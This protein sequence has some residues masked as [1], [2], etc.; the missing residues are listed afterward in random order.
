MLQAGGREMKSAVN[1]NYIVVMA[2]LVACVFGAYASAATT[3]GESDENLVFVT[4]IPKNATW[5]YSDNNAWPGNMWTDLS[6]DDSSW[7]SGMAYLATANETS[8]EG[9]TTVLAGGNP[10]YMTYYFRHVFYVEDASKVASM[11]FNIDY[12]DAYAIYLNGRMVA[13]SNFYCKWIS[14]PAICVPYHNSMIE[15]GDSGPNDPKFPRFDFNLDQLKY[16]AD[17]RNVLA[18]AIKQAANSSTDAAFMMTLYGWEPKT[19]VDADLLSRLSSY[20]WVVP[21]LAASAV[22][23]SAVAAYVR[24]RRAP[25]AGDYK[26]ERGHSYLLLEDEGS[27]STALFSREMSRGEYSGGLYI[28]RD[29][30]DEMRR[31]LNDGR[32]KVIWLTSMEAGKRVEGSI[33]PSLLDISVVI[34][35]FTSEHNNAIILFDGLQ[36]LINKIGLETI[37]EFL[38][39]LK[40]RVSQRNAVLVMPVVRLALE[41]KELG[42]L[43][44]ELDVLKPAGEVLEPKFQ[45]GKQA[46]VDVKKI[47]PE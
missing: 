34:D 39:N 11:S 21:V 22:G 36:Y 1:V 45:K 46:T 35:K 47:P 16:L 10:A 43:Q 32:V 25:K 27:N 19:K 2:V 20:A 40:D 30:P 14:H 31:K 44:T 24:R 4:Y 7:K 18:V 29:N 12:D 8:G 26:L 23:A 3:G 5:K 6:F 15:E 41:P 37:L 33:N 42:L 13:S 28:T 38:S 17:G 9:V